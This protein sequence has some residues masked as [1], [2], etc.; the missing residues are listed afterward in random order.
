MKKP[1]PNHEPHSLLLI[2]FS[3]LGDILHVLP[4]FRA[5]RK[6]L[7]TTRLFWAVDNSFA[8]VVQCLE[9]VKEVLPFERRETAERLSALTTFWSG[10]SLVWRYIKELRSRKIVGSLDFHGTF[11]SGFF[12]WFSGARRR[13]A[14]SSWRE[15]NRIFQDCAYKA[16]G[17]KM[18][19]IDRNMALLKFM[20][21]DAVPERVPVA[22]TDENRAVIEKYLHEQTIDSKRFVLIFPTSTWA[23]KQWSVEGYAETATN[24][25]DKT[26][27]PVLIAQDLNGDE[28][29]NAIAAS[30]K[31]DVRVTPFFGIKDLAVLCEEAAF[32]VGCD[33]GPLHLAAAMGTPVVGIYGPTDPVVFGPYWKPYRIVQH[34]EKC[35]RRCWKYRRSEDEIC[36][37]LKALK[38][39]KVIKACL[40]LYAETSAG[41]EATRKTA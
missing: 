19:A 1:F 10:I 13:L 26:G 9:G 39:E 23:I 8:D 14:F 5:L 37:C 12:A 28:M 34:D 41:Q 33:T 6:K 16:P 11:R 20:G 3:S 30:A 38:P 36:E 15:G 18:H 2:R 31:G 7:R 17:K 24:I 21:I 40:D 4:A 29:A 25:C 32:A 35:V 27:L 22:V